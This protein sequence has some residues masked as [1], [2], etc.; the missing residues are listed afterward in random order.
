MYRMKVCVNIYIYICTYL[1]VCI[2]Y[3]MIWYDVCIYMYMYISWYCVYIYISCY[4]VHIYINKY[5]YIY[6]RIMISCMNTQGL[7][8]FFIGPWVPGLETYHALA[9]TGWSRDKRRVSCS[10]ALRRDET[11]R[12]RRSLRQVN[13]NSHEAPI[14]AE[15]VKQQHTPKSVT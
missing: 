12:S 9:S 5:I 7:R 8:D 1:H 6:I 14:Q 11:R 13:V 3:D 4:H 10:A 2:W 15:D